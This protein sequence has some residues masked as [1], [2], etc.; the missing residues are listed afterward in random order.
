MVDSD[1]DITYCSILLH[2]MKSCALP[3]SLSDTLYKIIFGMRYSVYTAY[4]I[5]KLSY[6][7]TDNEPLASSRQGG[8][9][10]SPGICNSPMGVILDTA[11]SHSYPITFEHSGGHA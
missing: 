7:S 2:E 3:K 6:K 5:S 10:D 8:G 4:G 11:T 9:G 1:A